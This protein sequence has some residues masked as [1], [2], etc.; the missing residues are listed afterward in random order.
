MPTLIVN[1]GAIGD[2]LLSLPAFR[3]IKKYRG[4][5]TI[6]AKPE[7]GLFLK[8]AGECSSVIPSTATA[9]S[10]LYSGVIHPILAYFDD[11]WWFTRR[12]GL[13]PTV[14][15]M[16]D[17]KKKANVVFTVDE[18]PDETNCSI[19]QFNMVK[20]YL[21]VDDPIDGFLHHLSYSKPLNERELFD[22]AVHPG[23]GSK[24]KNLELGSFFEILNR[25]IKRYPSIKILFIL[26]PAEEYLTKDIEEYA[27]KKDG[28]V[29]ILMGQDLNTV[30]HTLGQTR[31]FL[32]NDS[33]ISHLAA[34]C[35]VETVMLFAPTN[36]KLWAP[37]L[38]NATF[39][40]SRAKC[41]P[42]G[43]KYRDCKE[44]I[45]LHEFDLDKIEEILIQKIE[46]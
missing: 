33:G 43:E 5:F 23:S 14:L 20:R 30:A 24:K 32:G 21:S 38:P 10:E 2:L 46:T 29:K 45:C 17:S 25:L 40:S 22:I 41:S 11:I 15:M 4:D 3:L 42:C 28:Q 37:I 7:N 8:A 13:V 18:G 27:I 44:N 6:A 26:G 36:P 39:I 12:R 35:G 1:Q 19:F 34:W 31:L 9:F 16:P